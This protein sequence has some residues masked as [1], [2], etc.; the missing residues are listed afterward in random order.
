MAATDSP[1]RP[2]LLVAVAVVLLVS[3]FGVWLGDEGETDPVA[4]GETAD[5]PP[6][7]DDGSLTTIDLGVAAEGFHRVCAV[8]GHDTPEAAAY[9]GPGPHPIVVFGEAGG[10]WVRS[11]DV[12]VADFP[13]NWTDADIRRVQLIGC[14]ST[15]RGAELG[16]CGATVA[17][18]AAHYELTVHE[19]RTGEVVAIFAATG[20]EYDCSALVAGENLARLPAGRMEDLIHDVIEGRA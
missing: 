17:I 20:H 6:P 12:A 15:G 1:R 4:H 10:E 2:V 14:L 16:T 7:S 5:S 19:A 3:A 8:P 9:E 18:H 13:A 11:L